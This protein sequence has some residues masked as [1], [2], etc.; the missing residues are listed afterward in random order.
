MTT[1]EEKNHKKQ[2]FKV[3][4]TDI[5]VEQR[6]QEILKLLDES[7]KILSNEIEKLKRKI[8]LNSLSSVELDAVY[9]ELKANAPIQEE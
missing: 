6:K 1:E 5:T 3:L 2:A 9:A 8:K 4:T 7:L